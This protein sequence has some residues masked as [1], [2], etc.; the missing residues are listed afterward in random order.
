MRTLLTTE[1]SRL[2]VWRTAA[3]G[4]FATTFAAIIDE[5]LV[6]AYGTLLVMTLIF[7][8]I[9]RDLGEA[10]RRRWLNDP[11]TWAGFGQEEDYPS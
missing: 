8:G 10:R 6:V 9:I 5:R 3:V 1:P 2:T 11:K 7:V 4:G